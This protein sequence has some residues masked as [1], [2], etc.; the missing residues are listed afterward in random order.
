MEVR[1][2]IMINQ[3]STASCARFGPA[4]YSTSYDLWTCLASLDLFVCLWLLRTICRPGG[5]HQ[6]KNLQVDGLDDVVVE[7]EEINRSERN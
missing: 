3:I 2:A 4:V 7:T 6:S 5:Y 1:I